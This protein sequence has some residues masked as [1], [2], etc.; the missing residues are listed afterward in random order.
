[1]KKL[2]LCALLGVSA[3]PLSGCVPVVA[4]G[5][6]AGILMAEDRRTSGTYLMDEEIEIRTAN[7]VRENHGENTHVNVTSFNRRVLLTGETPDTTVR[8][9]VEEIARTVPNVREV[10]NELII[11][12]TT[13][14]TARTNDSYITAKV[15]TRF[16]EDKRFN[17]H[18]VKVITE[19]GTVFLMGMVKH[20]EGN[21]AAE[22]AAR[23]GGVS[24]VVKVFE[25]MD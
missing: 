25:Y 7:R 13:T 24:K 17:A 11:G 6:G 10:Q 15:K 3:I 18:H 9:K 20:E 23:T 2:I 21:A 14:Y 16:L 19:A 1:M 5:V 4:G 12:G 8:A 22:V